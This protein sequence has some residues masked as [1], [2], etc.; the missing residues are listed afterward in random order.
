MDS[1]ETRLKCKNCGLRFDI[2]RL[3]PCC[4]EIIC[5]KCLNKL[6]QVNKKVIKS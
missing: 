5:E 6:K 1:I 3:L 4:S 2:P